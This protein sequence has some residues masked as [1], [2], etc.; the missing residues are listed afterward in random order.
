M[1]AN[2]L[3]DRLSVAGQIEPADVAEIKAAGFT[4]IICNRPDGEG[5]TQ[6]TSSEVGAAASE[7]GLPYHYNPLVPGELTPEIIAKQGEVL[8]SAEGPVFAYCGSGMRAS[9]L[10]ALANPEG[11]D[12]ETRIAR[13]AAVGYDLEPLREKL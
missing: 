4:A 6:P 10:W 9:M 3:T 5:E 13:A 2:K 11:L 1:K 7:A 8:K 12:V